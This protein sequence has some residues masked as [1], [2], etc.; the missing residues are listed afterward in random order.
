MRD[1]DRD[2]YSAFLNKV[3]NSNMMKV[4]EFLI[5]QKGFEF[6]LTDLKNGTKLSKGTIYSIWDNVLENNYVIEKRTIG[7][8]KLFLLNENDDYVKYFINIYDC[9][10]KDELKKMRQQACLQIP[11]E[12]LIVKYSPCKEHI[13]RKIREMVIHAT[14]SA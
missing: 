3:G 13:Y 2:N 5:E 9:V 14:S 7:K 1:G 8:T 12:A 11:K 6:T 10:I 4:M